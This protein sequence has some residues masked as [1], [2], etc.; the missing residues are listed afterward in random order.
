MLPE[1]EPLASKS[2]KTKKQTDEDSFIR[3]ALGNRKFLSGLIILLAFT[4]LGILGPF[5]AP[6][7]P[8]NTSFQSW[9]PPSTAHLLGTDYI[10]HDV[11]SWFVI[12]TGTSL[13]VGATVSLI[14][15]FLGTAVGLISGYYSGA[16]YA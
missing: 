5:I 9:L 4:L 16:R 15:T 2:L 8:Y 3:G 11:Y 1:L 12:G 10:G 7:S 14:T 6:Y 13:F